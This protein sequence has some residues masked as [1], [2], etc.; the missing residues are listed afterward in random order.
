MENLDY[1]V[2]L[3]LSMYI[4]TVRLESVL[5]NCDH[6]SFVKYLCIFIIFLFEK[7]PLKHYQRL[8]LCDG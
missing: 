6:L 7:Y 1:V 8:T 5:S 3:C 2:S 4:L